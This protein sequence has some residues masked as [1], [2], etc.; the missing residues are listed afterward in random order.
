MIQWLMKKKII[1]KIT[2]VQE[3]IQWDF[4]HKKYNNINFG[5]KDGIFLIQVGVYTLTSPS[6]DAV[7]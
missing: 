7:T 4:I 3:F 2:P 1:K 5:K 6:G